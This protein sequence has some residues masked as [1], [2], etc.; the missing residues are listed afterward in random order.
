MI[1]RYR[2]RDR[3]RCQRIHT[4]TRLAAVFQAADLIYPYA[5]QRGELLNREITGDTGELQPLPQCVHVNGL[6]DWHTITS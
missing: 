4:D 3:K 1:K 6:F 2:Q 5:T